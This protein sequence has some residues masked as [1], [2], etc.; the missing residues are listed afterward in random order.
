MSHDCAHARKKVGR[1]VHIRNRPFITV[2]AREMASPEY[3][4]IQKSFVKLK[5][6]VTRGQI[7]SALFAGDCIT[8]DV[9]RMSTNDAI[10]QD[11]RANDIMD[12]VLNTVRISSAKFE[13]FCDALTEELIAKDLV[14]KL[15]GMFVSRVF[16][17]GE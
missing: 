4:A 9:M 12:D 14:E 7:P 8:Q 11:K 10:S 1:A 2:Q 13:D 3:S 5:E 16:G 17:W 15:R 6:V